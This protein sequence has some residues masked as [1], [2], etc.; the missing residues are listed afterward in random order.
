MKKI[1]LLFLLLCLPFI[2]TKA[3]DIEELDNLEENIAELNKQLDTFE[4]NRLNQMYPVG[5][6]FETT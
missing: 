4:T 2:N 1:L 3:L 6:I 5:S